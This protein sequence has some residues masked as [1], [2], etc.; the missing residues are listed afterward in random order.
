MTMTARK[1]VGS[2]DELHEVSIRKTGFDDFGDPGYRQG[3][4][5]LLDA[6]DTDLRL[7]DTGWETVYNSIVDTLCARLYTQNGWA[8]H[9]E[10]LAIPIHRPLVIAALPRT[11]TTAL[12]RLLSVDPQFQK[13]ET[14]LLRTPMIRPPRETW[15]THPAY[16]ECAAHLEAIFSR[17]PGVQKKHDASADE[18]EECIGL[19][20]QN[21]VSGII[22][23]H[24]RLPTYARWFLSQSVGESYRRYADILR[25]IGAREPHKRWLLKS[26]HHMAEID[27]LLD[28]FPDACVI[29]THRD[30]IRA[31]PSFCSLLHS[32]KQLLEGDSAQPDA[33][34]PQQCAHW[35]KAL[36]CLQLARRRSPMQFFDVDH[37]RFLMDPLGVVQSIYEYFSLTLSPHTEQR[38]RAWVAA[39]PTSRHGKHQYTVDSWGITHTQI[40]DT[41]ADYRAQHQFN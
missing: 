31:I 29:Q 26:P 5:A 6:Y 14:W 23:V 16:R 19:L 8:E 22:P 41:F 7:T 28:V 36:D 11:G 25:L 35:R 33:I 10:V 38:M 39:S 17:M 9:P 30:P 37:R 4:R 15:E 21:F 3:L 1:F 12:H 40:C 34:G 27:T 20:L 18:A 13:L 2:E 32:G 24:T